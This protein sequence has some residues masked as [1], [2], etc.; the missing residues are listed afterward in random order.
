MVSAKTT[1]FL[2]VESQKERKRCHSASPKTCKA[3]RNRHVETLRH[4]NET[5]S[6][7]RELRVTSSKDT[8]TFDGTLSEGIQELG[9]IS[10]ELEEA[11]KDLASAL[12]AKKL[13]SRMSS[14]ALSIDSGTSSLSPSRCS[15]MSSPCGYDLEAKADLSLVA[16]VQASVQ[17]NMIMSTLNTA[18]EVEEKNMVSR[19]GALCRT[20]QEKFPKINPKVLSKMSCSSTGDSMDSSDDEDEADVDEIFLAFTKC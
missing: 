20:S 17:M 9:R 19:A 8:F 10:R 13:E 11:E 7:L 16:A 2:V 12:E 6:S 14:M 4:L 1:Q 18:F 5:T 3:Y 15:G